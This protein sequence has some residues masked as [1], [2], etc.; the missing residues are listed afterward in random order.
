[1]A[2]PIDFDFTNLP[3]LTK[4]EDVLKH[5]DW[6]IH[7]LNEMEE[8]GYKLI[9]TDSGH[10]K[11]IVFH[12]L[13]NDDSIT[14]DI[15]TF[16]F[17][18]KLEGKLFVPNKGSYGEGQAKHAIE[19]CK[20]IA[21]DMSEALMY[22]GAL[23]NIYLPVIKEN[24]NNQNFFVEHPKYLQHASDELLNNPSF[25]I[26]VVDS[27]SL[28]YLKDFTDSAKDNLQVLELV[29]NKTKDENY[30]FDGVLSDTMK[31]RAGNKPHE[32]IEKF[33]ENERQKNKLETELPEKPSKAD[34]LVS[35]IDHDAEA[36]TKRS[37]SKLKI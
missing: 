14:N 23:E 13:S 36:P 8:N 5:L 18:K 12:A 28:Y 6:M 11:I 17:N 26:R 2:L 25:A 7:S 34:R 29:L 27:N 10:Q 3:K 9:Q 33:I 22:G 37:G 30:I 21:R 32:F 35:S 15:N 1:M 16:C 19:K 4:N 20:Q 24:A 31:Q